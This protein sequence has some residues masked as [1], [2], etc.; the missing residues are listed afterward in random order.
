MP[1]DAPRPVI[2]VVLR[3][4]PALEVGPARLLEGGRRNHGFNPPSEELAGPE[5][6]QA[7]A[8]EG[9][10]SQQSHLREFL[11]EGAYGRCTE[12]T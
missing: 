4:A 12:A 5:R 8:L 6:A 3:V 2:C 7:Q 1:D 10:G 11:P 9:A